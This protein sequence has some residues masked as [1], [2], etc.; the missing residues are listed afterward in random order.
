MN[1]LRRTGFVLAATIAA[2]PLQA[3]PA[4]AEALVLVIG[5]QHSAYERA[6]QLVAT[7]DRLK[8][9]NPG[10]PVAILIDGDTLEYGNVVARRSAGEIDFTMYSA[11]ARRAP[12]ILSLG[13]HEPEFYDLAE[14]VR[15]I[16]ATG[17]TVVSNIVNRATNQ[18]F[19][20]ASTKLKLGEREAVVV[21]MTTDHLSTYRIAVRPSLDLA[22]PVV[23]AK[24]NF[25][26]LLA[27]APLKIVLSHAGMAADREM[28]S[29]VP[30]GTLFSGAHEH[31]RF[32]H[33][34]GRSVYFH[35][36]SWN[37]YLSLAWLCRDPDGGTRWNVEQIP[38]PL[39]APADPEMAA[40]IQAVFAKYLT[41]EDT[42]V[43]GKSSHEMRLS[44]AGP[45][46]ARAVR[47]RAGVDAA[48][49]G[50]TTF[51]TG[52]PAGEVNRFQFDAYV[53]FDGAIFT[54]EVDGAR[55]KQ[56]LAAANQGPDT[57]FAD[58]QGDFCFADGPTE[59]DP[60]ARYRIATN[61][62]VAR[63]TARYF[64]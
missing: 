40:K 3:A 36:A 14:T 5:D 42:A 28:F 45:F 17:I 10:L 63:N 11:L 39:S 1:V 57:P 24:K 43:V 16:E 44:E 21:G 19:A 64:G 38:I 4:G 50:N 20:P 7:V 41:A 6:A 9:E 54:T 8:T 22:N 37:R 55:L 34:M 49:V 59:I 48:F 58:R 35:T 32:V 30:E 13:N 56:L 61:D 23:W 25:P 26:T 12:T 46:A 31:L 18:P 33:P 47:Q 62:W 29:L 15:R 52:L 27:E 2:L 60:A 53:R 51:G